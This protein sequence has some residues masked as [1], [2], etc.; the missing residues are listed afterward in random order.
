[1]QNGNMTTPEAVTDRV[2]LRKALKSL[3]LFHNLMSQLRNRSRSRL[4]RTAFDL[5]LDTLDQLW[6]DLDSVD[7]AIED[8]QMR[9]TYRPTPRL[10][11]QNE[12]PLP[13]AGKAPPVLTL[14]S[15]GRDA[16]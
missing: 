3:S 1:M 16:R 2:T 6:L 15:G 14:L 12:T 4:V 7:V 13:A 8:A 5:A 11:A 10:A 9:T